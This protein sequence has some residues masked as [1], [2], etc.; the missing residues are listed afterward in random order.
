MP[1]SCAFP[2]S[3]APPPQRLRCAGEGRKLS[4]IS[5]CLSAALPI[6]AV[7]IAGFEALMAALPEKIIGP[8]IF[9]ELH[10]EVSMGLLSHEQ[11]H[12]GKQ[13]CFLVI[14]M[15]GSLCEV[16]ED[17]SPLALLELKGPGKVV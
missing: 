6:C 15:A 7:I 11:R 5:P 3:A 8:I 14:K 1:F 2:W 4:V 10:Q 17:P 16:K 13:H 12:V 9:N